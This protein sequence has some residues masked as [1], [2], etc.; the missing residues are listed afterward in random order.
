MGWGSAS[1]CSEDGLVDF[2]HHSPAGRAVD[3]GQDPLQPAVPGCPSPCM[4]K[5]CHK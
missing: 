1:M 5:V 3:S 2:V 4:V